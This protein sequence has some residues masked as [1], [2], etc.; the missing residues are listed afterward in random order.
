MAQCPKCKR[1]LP[2]SGK[3]PVCDLARPGGFSL[4]TFLRPDGSTG[5][6]PGAPAG[7]SIRSHRPFL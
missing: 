1:N 3:C 2:V 4:G 5:P 7:G 6:N